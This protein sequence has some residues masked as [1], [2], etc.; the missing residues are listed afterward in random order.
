[1]K[2]LA[3]FVHTVKTIQFLLRGRRRGLWRS[4]ECIKVDNIRDRGYLHGKILYRTA[5]VSAK[6]GY[7][8]G[9]RLVLKTRPG[10]AIDP[11]SAH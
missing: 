11:R 5:H 9:I 1:M 8:E 6:R 7:F 3:L 2:S 4:Q 10:S